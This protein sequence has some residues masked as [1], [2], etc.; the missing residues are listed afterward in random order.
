M[1]EMDRTVLNS[2]ILSEPHDMAHN[3]DNHTPTDP[4]LELFQSGQAKM[5]EGE[6]A[7]LKRF[8]SYFDELNQQPVPIAVK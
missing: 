2:I 8:L 4:L 5:V 6:L 3:V 1:L 7:E